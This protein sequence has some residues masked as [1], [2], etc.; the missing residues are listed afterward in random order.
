MGEAEE[1][2]VP[3]G[4][5]AVI[6]HEHGPVPPREVLLE[7]QHLPAVAQRVL[8]Q[9]AQFGER[10]EHDAR[11]TGA[12]HDVLHGADRG[13][14]LHLGRMEHGVARIAARLSSDGMSSKISMLSSDQPW[15][16]AVARS[17]SA[18]SDNATKRPRSPRARP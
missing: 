15:L 7:R 17:S 12:L 1:H 6:H 18:D 4:T 16:F 2:H 13:A 11:G 9:Q 14:E 8:G 3:R 5:G 10:I